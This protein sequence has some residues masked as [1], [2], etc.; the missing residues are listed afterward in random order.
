MRREV[1]EALA[2]VEAEL[3][4]SFPESVKE[5]L[6]TRRSGQVRV[7]SEPWRFPICDRP[8][9][10]DVVVSQSKAFRSEW[11]LA[12]VVIA[13]DGLGNDLLLLPATETNT[14]GVTLYVILRDA[15]EIREVSN[16]LEDAA[17]S[18]RLDYLYGDAYDYRLD[19]DG[20]VVKFDMDAYMA[21]LMGEDLAEPG[22]DASDD[23][24]KAWLAH[25]LHERKHDDAERVLNGLL[26]LSEKAE[27]QHHRAFAYWKL[28]ELY[29]NGFG[30][31]AADPELASRHNQ[32][33]IDLGSTQALT[34]RAYWHVLGEVLPKDL[35]RG[36]ELL[37]AADQKHRVESG[38]SPL[39]PMLEAL[40]AQIEAER[41]NA[42]D[43]SPAAE[44]RAIRRL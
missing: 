3:N 39:T 35:Q 13:N 11:K 24:R 30:P 32:T 29:S 38:A 8:P 31:I 42:P 12:G 36:Y 25:C 27:S 10:A 28:A 43:E 44:V 5:F 15:A 22:P 40:R 14:L 19:P 16:T 17:R 33:A 37:L 9:S 21:S 1:V 6:A 4:V 18:E 2:Q 7:G 23:E 20:T 34:M 26:S 41:G